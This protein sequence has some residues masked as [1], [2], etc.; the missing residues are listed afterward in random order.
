MTILYFCLGLLLGLVFLVLVIKK[1]RKSLSLLHDK[2]L[3]LEQ[4]KK[5]A[6]EFMHN[7]AVAIGE[8]VAKKDLYQRV[9]HTAVLTTGAMS[10]CV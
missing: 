1:E 7:L 8:G 5:I 4:E 9:A 3:R 2:T 10:S 6:V